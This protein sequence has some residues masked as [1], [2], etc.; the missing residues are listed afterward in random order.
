MT[1]LKLFSGNSGELSKDADP[2]AAFLYNY[3]RSYLVSLEVNS[4][5]GAAALGV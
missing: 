4:L 3:I 2:F 5:V 1:R